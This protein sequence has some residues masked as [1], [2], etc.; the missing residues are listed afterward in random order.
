MK[1]RLRTFLKHSGRALLFLAL[2][3]LP[4]LVRMGYYYRPRLYTPQPVPRPDFA[5]VNVPTVALAAFADTDAWQGKGQVIIDRAHENAV[6]DADLN[7]LLARLTTRGME[8]AS[9]TPADSLPDM[10]HDAAALVVIAPHQSFYAWEIEAVERF[11]EKGGHVLL[12]ADPG[13]YDLRTEFDEY[14]LESYVPY[15]DVIAINSLAAPFGLAFA[16]D[17]IYNTTE[18]AGNYQHVILKDFAPSPLTAGLEKVIFY[19]AHSISAGKQTVITADERTTSSLSEQTGGLA[20]MSL[21]GDGRVLAISDFTFMTEPYNGSADNNR[22]LANIADYLTGAERTF[23]LLDFPHFF[24][25]Q[26]DLV[27]L[28]GEPGKAALSVEEIDQGYILQS[29]F[30]SAG[31]TL[32]LQTQPDAGHDTIFVGLYHNVEFSPQAS[33][34]LIGRGISFT[35]ETVAQQRATPTPTPRYTP[36]PTPTPRTSPTPTPE[37]LRDWIDIA[38]L[39]QVEAQEIALLYHNEEGNRQVVMV[40]AFTDEGLNAAIQ[41]LIFGDFTQCLTKNDL[42]G[43]PT[44]ISLALCPTAYE[45]SPVEPTPTPIV[46]P[47]PTQESGIAPTPTPSPAAE[48]GILIVADDDG[49]GVYESWTSAYSFQDSAIAAGYPATVWSTLWDGEVTLEQVQSYDAVIWCTGDY[50]EEEMTPSL[51]DLMTIAY[52]I[53]DGGNLILAG[54]FIGESEDRESGLL[55]D[56]QVA[57]ADHPLAEGFE[58]DQVI[59]LERLLAN[60]DYSPYLLGEP[61]ADAIVFSRGPASESAGE[62]I[63]TASEDEF[64]DSRTIFIGFPIFLMPYEEQLQFGT[65]A[66]LWL[67]EDTQ[68]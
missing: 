63:I 41:R 11:V 61:G 5:E 19:H 48:G 15:S 37:S 17:Y 4:I 57:Q 51:D 14:G 10:L 59:T 7:V 53:A 20:T 18:H 49:T 33:E 65:N 42:S 32:R 46:V 55:L 28:V 27:P 34:I 31:K 35:L 1:P 62:A 38:G 24:D 39:G 58:E 44:A 6:D 2:L 50:K 40:L 21:G 52:Y 30:E 13:R 68:G 22:L 12:V 56:I 54:A 29:T 45:P 67:M 36:T 25:S 16:D 8:A 66:I 43:D 64:T 47:I 23:G 3:G 26:V 9:L 60:E